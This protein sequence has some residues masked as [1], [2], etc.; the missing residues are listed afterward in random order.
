MRDLRDLPD[1]TNHFWVSRKVTLGQTLRVIRERYWRTWRI[2]RR[3]S[4]RWAT[5]SPSS[6]LE[7][8][9]ISL[10]VGTKAGLMLKRRRPMPN[11]G[12]KQRAR[13]AISPHRVTG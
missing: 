13:P 8:R 2:V 11:K 4:A 3:R 7:Q 1:L 6:R 10:I 9:T 5:S 12:R